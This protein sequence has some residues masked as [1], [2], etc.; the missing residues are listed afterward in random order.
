MTALADSSSAP[1]QANV[2]EFQTEDEAVFW[3]MNNAME[4]GIAVDD[5]FNSLQ[6]SGVDAGELSGCVNTKLSPASVSSTVP[7]SIKVVQIIIDVTI[8]DCGNILCSTMGFDM[9]WSVAPS[10]GASIL[11][12]MPSQTI[13]Q[14]CVGNSISSRGFL[15][16]KSDIPRGN[17]SL[18][19]KVGGFGGA[20]YYYIPVT[21]S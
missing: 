10:A 2:M 16:L 20:S 9:T 7:K 5:L 8:G 14:I 11:G 12:P 3:L 1:I 4:N 13:D 19:I 15:I 6:E 17:Y 21:I 18:K